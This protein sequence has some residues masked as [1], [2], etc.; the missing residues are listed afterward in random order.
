MVVGN[1]CD[2]LASTEA[3]ESHPRWLH[4]ASGRS[5]AQGSADPLDLRHGDA[6]AACAD[7]IGN[8]FIVDC[9]S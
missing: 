2:A 3:D 9:S 8:L 5:F 1:L 6:S 4:G 7:H